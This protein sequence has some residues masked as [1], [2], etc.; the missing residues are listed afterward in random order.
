MFIHQC[1]KKLFIFS[2]ILTFFLSAAL[3]AGKTN[4]TKQEMWDAMAGDVDHWVDGNGRP[5]DNE[6]KETV[7]ALNLLGIKTTAS[8]E[9]HLDHGFAYPWVQIGNYPPELEKM[10]DEVSD[11][12]NQIKNEEEMLEKK[13]PKLLY[14]DM[15]VTPEAKQLR[16][17]YK[18]LHP[19]ENSIRQIEIKSLEPLNKL[20]NQFYKSHKSSYDKILIA[21]SDSL[22]RL[23]SIGADKQ[24][25]RAQK[26]RSLRL[27]AYQKEMKAF[28]LFLKQKFMSS[29]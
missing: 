29:N 11:I 21:P 22:I 12:R 14:N 8:C 17:L 15:Y 1:F 4:P 26:E 20:L 3:I 19:I 2:T 10:F 28:A 13:F 18:R 7:I 9:G 6:I 23:H 24:I 25:M 27:T 16:S 5:L